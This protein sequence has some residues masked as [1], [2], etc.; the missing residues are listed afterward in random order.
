MEYAIR[1]FSALPGKGSFIPFVNIWANGIEPGDKVPFILVGSHRRVFVA[2]FVEERATRSY[3][4]TVAANW[5]DLEVAA[6]DAVQEQGG[7]VTD[8]MLYPCPAEIANRARF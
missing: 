1:Q 2:R 8:R 7:N 6:V 3:D 4:W 5:E